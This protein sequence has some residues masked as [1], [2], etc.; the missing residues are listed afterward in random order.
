MM[1]KHGGLKMRIRFTLNDA[2]GIL[3]DAGVR[4]ARVRR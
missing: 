2:G 1:M 4:L 3:N